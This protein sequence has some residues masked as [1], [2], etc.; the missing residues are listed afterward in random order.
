MIRLSSLEINNWYILH[1]RKGFETVNDKSNAS[2]VTQGAIKMLATT[3]IFV[4]LFLGGAQMQ[5]QQGMYT[6]LWNITHARLS[7]IFY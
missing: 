1:L 4:L 2:I 5:Q 6:L 3:L 7:F